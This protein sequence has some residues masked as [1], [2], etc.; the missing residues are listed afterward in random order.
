M[1]LLFSAVLIIGDMAYTEI[2]NLY[3]QFVMIYVSFIINAAWLFK[4][5]LISIPP[6]LLNLSYKN[7]LSSKYNW[8]GILI[9]FKIVSTLRILI[10][11]KAIKSEYWL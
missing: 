10:V 2:P 6:I 7:I 9:N 4:K 3:S 5:N 1:I 8:A 11:M